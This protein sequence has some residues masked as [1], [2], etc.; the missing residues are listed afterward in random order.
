MHFQFISLELFTLALFLF[1]SLVIC[2]AGR[3]RSSSPTRNPS[4]SQLNNAHLS[5]QCHPCTPVF[6]PQHQCSIPTTCERN[7]QYSI[8]LNR[9]SAEYVNSHFHFHGQI[10][11]GYWDG[12]SERLQQNDNSEDN[13]PIYEV[14]LL[15][16]QKV[17]L[18]LIV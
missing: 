10:D 6:I 16:Y 12:S 13:Y 15:K 1:V 8:V 11:L 18:L 3:S 4:P 17:I 9:C 7:G 14:E 2:E 5:N